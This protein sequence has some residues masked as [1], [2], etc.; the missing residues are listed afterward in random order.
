MAASIQYLQRGEID[1]AKWDACVDTATNGLIYS[2]SYYLDA[3]SANWGGLVLNNYEAVMPLTW[4][5]KWGIYYLYQPFLTAQTGLT[6]SNTSKE[7]L[8]LFLNAIPRKFLLWDVSLNHHTLFQLDD[9]PLHLRKNYILPLQAAYENLNA[10]YRQNVKRN[11]KKALQLGC[12]VRK[13]I[14]VELVV[15]LAKEFTPGIGQFE[16]E[17]VN[18]EKL[19]HF[20]LQRKQAVTYG[21]YSSSQQLI[22]SA[23]FVFSHDRAYYILV[24]NHP[25]GKTLGASHLLV[26]GFIKDHAAQNLTLDFEG[27]D[28]QTLAF[29][30]SS[31]GAVEEK[32]TALKLNRLPWL[33]KWMKQ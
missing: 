17:F 24:G 11:I 2:Y 19:Y 29:F 27:S 28:V 10:N 5:K 26:D 18:F 8:R 12:Y 13:G 6:S 25:N 16:R 3:M 4:R 1:I 7:M 14:A 30:Y 15:T 20:L 32:Y 22:A 21:V 31:F 33:L 9:Y 23:V